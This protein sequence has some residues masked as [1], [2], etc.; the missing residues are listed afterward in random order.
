M[1][2]L[3]Q[4]L[5]FVTGI[6]T[7]IGK[8]VVTSLLARNLRSKGINVVTQ[9]LVQTGC[10]GIAEDILKHRELAGMELLEVDKDFTSCPFVFEFPASPHLAA[11]MEGRT[12]D[13]AVIEASTARLL[14]EFEVVLIEGAGG[15]FVPLTRDY[16]TIDYVCDQK[17]PVVLVTSPRLGSINHTLLTLEVCRSRNID[18]AMLVYNDFEPSASEIANDSKQVMRKY[19]DENLPTT[20]FVEVGEL[21]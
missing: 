3:D 5:Y 17:L 2:T 1:K 6:D 18:V 10:R 15:L 13:M 9:K 11:E 4:K 7:G 16:F 19:L 14:E 8:T 12:I 20:V 21:G